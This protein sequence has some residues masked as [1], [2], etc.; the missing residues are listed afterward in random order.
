VNARQ[1]KPLLRLH[2]ASPGSCKIGEGGSLKI[3]KKEAGKRVAMFAGEIA[4]GSI[5]WG[6][7]RIRSA[8]AYTKGGTAPS[9]GD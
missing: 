7:R 5:G 4:G 2:I 8:S 9:Y 3:K 6:N 1:I